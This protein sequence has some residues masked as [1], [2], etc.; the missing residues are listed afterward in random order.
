[1]S[2]QLASE[3]SVADEGLYECAAS[4]AYGDDTDAAFL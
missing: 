2:Q 4:N 3:L 1:M